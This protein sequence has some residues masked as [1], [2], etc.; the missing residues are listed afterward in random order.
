MIN[1][2]IFFSTYFAGFYYA[3]TVGA[4][5]AFTVYQAVYFFNP[6]RRWW[7]YMVPDIPYSF[8]TVCLMA[9]VFFIN[10]DK[11]KDNKIFAAPQF[12]WF[13]MLV[14]FYWIASFW[15]VYPAYHDLQF[16]AYFK[17]AI[18]MTIAYKLCD[19][20]L[21]LDKI[22]MGHIFGAW[23]VSFV[24]FQ[25]GRNSG[26]R[27][28]GIGTVDAPDANGIAAA[29]APAVVLCLYFFWTRKGIKNKAIFGF[30]MAF[31]ANAIVLINSRGAMLAVAASVMYFMHKMFFS[32]VKKRFQKLTVVGMIVAGLAGAYVIVDQ[33]FIDRIKS[34][35]EQTEV[36]KSKESGATRTYYWIAAYEMSKDFPHGQGARGFNYYAPIY[37]PQD[38]DTG[39]SRNRT[40][41]STWFEALS[42]I[43]YQGLIVFLLLLFSCYR[44]TLA[45]RRKL[46]ADG[47]V[48]SYYK[49]I[50]IEGAL[51][52]FVVAM[53]FLNRVRAEILYW[54][55]L[56]TAV[57][58]NIYIA[59]PK[60][61][62]EAA[63]RE[64]KL[65]NRFS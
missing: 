20:E 10:K 46:K 2:L 39:G 24:A 31:L 48:D 14:F 26:D 38:L 30:A 54:C 34:I 45:C 33:A 43:G 29:I 16:T 1:V 23:Y 9:L 32:R 40:V 8:F 13:Y 17:L 7:G 37:L 11:L 56:Y 58:Y 41:H 49:I 12:K 63:E 44:C 3:L 53:T 25:V 35:V 36:D 6:M 60:A 22:L 5:F 47:N 61:Q 18:I 62:A 51:I 52:S 64:A 42:E 21:D 27:V 59:K 65:T 50:A 57:A 28:E 19:T 4:V 15:A 55:I